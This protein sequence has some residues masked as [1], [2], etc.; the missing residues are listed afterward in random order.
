MP[1]NSPEAHRPLPERPNLRH[2]KDQAKDLLQAGT[3]QSITEA[4]FKI[5]RS[6][7]FASWP[8]LKAHIDSL[9]EIGELKQAIDTNDLS[10][11][12]TLMTR[13]PELHRAR[14]AMERMDRSRGLQNA[15][16]PGRRPSRRG[17]PWPPG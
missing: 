1:T 9:E 7:G 14:W 6:Y 10:E 12:K 4:Q 3:A 5:A 8:R 15:A 16:Y 17:W 11:V 2:L 13:N